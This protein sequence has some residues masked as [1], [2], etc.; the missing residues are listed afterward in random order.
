MSIRT[1][2]INDTQ[3]TLRVFVSFKAKRR[4]ND[5]IHLFMHNKD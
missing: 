2:K 5:I 3:S 4:H 1:R